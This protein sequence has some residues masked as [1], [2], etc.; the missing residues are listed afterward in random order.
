M[1]SRAISAPELPL[2]KAEGGIWVKC[3]RLQSPLPSS[4]TPAFSLGFMCYSLKHSAINVLPVKL[5]L[6]VCCPRNSTFATTSLR[7]KFKIIEKTVQLWLT[8]LFPPSQTYC[9]HLANFLLALHPWNLLL[10]PIWV[11]F[12]LFPPLRTLPLGISHRW[13]VRIPE[14]SALSC[15]SQP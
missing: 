4:P 8:W 9:H 11:I 7:T 10:S 6:R 3:I 1:T 5:H 15:F 2:G 14:V 13:F 12:L